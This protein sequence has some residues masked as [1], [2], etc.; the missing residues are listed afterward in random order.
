MK[1]VQYFSDEYLAQCR[2]MTP[3]Q[4][5]RYLDDFRRLHA[6]TPPVSKLISLK[7]PEDLLS[8]F[9]AMA[10][11]TGTPYQTQIKALMKAWV[12]NQEMPQGTRHG[13]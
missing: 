10:R 8:A 3:D 12:V 11:L 6:A 13:D 4:I 1:A 5:L 9:K 7:V 2:A